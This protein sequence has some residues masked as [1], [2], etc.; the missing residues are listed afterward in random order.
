MNEQSQELSGQL[1]LSKAEK[2]RTVCDYHNDGPSNDNVE[3]SV[4][5]LIVSNILFWRRGKYIMYVIK[6]M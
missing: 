1:Y 4:K 6:Q 2:K 3:S 5:K